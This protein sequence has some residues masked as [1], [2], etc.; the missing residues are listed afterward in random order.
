MTCWA[1]PDRHR[2]DRRLHAARCCTALAHEPQRRRT[3]SAAPGI[4]APGAHPTRELAAQ[5]EESVRDLRQVPAAHP[6]RVIFG[7]VGMN[8]Q[9]ASVQAAAWTSWWPR[10]AACS[11][12]SSRACWTWARCRSWCWTRPTACSTWA[13]SMTSRRC[14][15]LVPKDKQSLLFSATFSDE[16]RDLADT[17]C[18]KNPQ[19]VAGHA[20]QHHGAT[21]HAGDPPGRPRQARRPCWRTS[22]SS[23]NW[24]QVLVFTRTKYGANQRGRVSE[25]E[26]HQRHGACTATR[27]RPRAPRRWPASRA[28]TCRVLVA[29][30]IAAR[31]IDIDDLPH[32]VNYEMPNV[33]RRLCAPHR[34]HRPRRRRRRSRQPGVPGRRRLHA[35]HRALHQAG[36]RG[37][38]CVEGFSPSPAKEAEPIAMG[39]QTIWG[40]AGKPPSRD[41]MQAAA[42]DVD[43]D[44]GTDERRRRPGRFVRAGPRG[45]GGGCG[46]AAAVAV[47]A[48]PLVIGPAAR[49]RAGR[50]S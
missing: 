29:T 35:G 33:P 39:R 50:R 47:Y 32:V 49:P 28:A 18:S 41:V 12:C 6:A 40:G 1:A 48:Y 16:I 43:R 22:S 23:S 37:A 9:I 4:R 45:G 42:A 11:T 19:S 2:Q 27:A 5:V 24:S 38:R 8:P 25:Q 15:P 10:P 31:G 20:A 14:W 34:P 26:R 44:A 30:D 13:S 7:G 21:H 17:A 3:S 46:H 36:H